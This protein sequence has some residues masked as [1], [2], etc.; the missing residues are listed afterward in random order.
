MQDAKIKPGKGK[1][2][3]AH[4]ALSLQE[5][6]KPMVLVSQYKLD[7]SQSKPLKEREENIHAV[8]LV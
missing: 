2:H 3:F 4:N 6:C 8:Q 5:G 1:D 7:R